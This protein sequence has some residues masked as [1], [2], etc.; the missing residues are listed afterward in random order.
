MIYTYFWLYI[1][2]LYRT[3]A[4]RWKDAIN[5]P[6]TTIVRLL[7]ITPGTLLAGKWY[8]ILY[9]YPHLQTVYLLIYLMIQKFQK[10]LIV[11]MNFL[12]LVKLSLQYELFCALTCC[13]RHLPMSGTPVTTCL[14]LGRRHHIPMAGTPVTTYH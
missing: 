6:I 8:H 1:K 5:S 3:P 2:D 7:C 14:C 12:N 13:R 9:K 11:I 10:F 4:H